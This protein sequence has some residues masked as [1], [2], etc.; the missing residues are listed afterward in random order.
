[1]VCRS[2]R[3]EVGA[4]VGVGPEVADA[5]DVLVAV[6]PTLLFGLCSVKQLSSQ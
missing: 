3:R 1:M 2:Q 4:G 6:D 5:P